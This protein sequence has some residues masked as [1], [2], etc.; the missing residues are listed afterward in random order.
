M[1]S[2]AH[3][4]PLAA[5]RL[6][7][8]PTGTGME[9]RAARR[10][11]VDDPASAATEPPL[12]LT[13][14]P[15]DVIDV[16]VTQAARDARDAEDPVGAICAWM[17]SFCKA[18][19]VQG[20]TGCDD[21]W[22]RLAL[23]AFG[24][25]PD[26]KKPAQMWYSWR[27]LFATACEFLHGPNAL[28]FVKTVGL[29]PAFRW[30]ASQRELDWE[31]VRIFES[32]IR[33]RMRDNPGT[34]FD[35]ERDV[36]KA[37]WEALSDP[38]DPR[39]QQAPSRIDALAMLLVLKGAE[40]WADKKYRALD[41]EIDTALN[42]KFEGEIDA[43]EALRLIRDAL[44]RGA[45]VSHS[46]WRYHIM[47]NQP[48]K[49]DHTLDSAVGANAGTATINLLL[50]RG[51]KALDDSF[52]PSFLASFL[53]ALAM[54]SA[55]PYW[56]ADRAATERLIEAARPIIR[57]IVLLHNPHEKLESARRT[58]DGFSRRHGPPSDWLT[59]AWKRLFDVTQWMDPRELEEHLPQMADYDPTAWPDHE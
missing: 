43:D 18:A 51:A 33:Y 28:P 5:L 3:L 29:P 20:V 46:G 56:S 50:D 30:N 42:R 37:S 10:R 47:T 1:R 14:L 22:Y 39:R 31:L 9:T 45:L 6:G 53:R 44:D 52:H 4:P 8:A 12:R 41:S 21:R 35:E 59:A 24:V 2:T 11:R 49:I 15:R 58:V 23:Q 48:I 40:P 25:P 19:K 34:E 54:E 26:A 36:Q 27:Y 7:T 16:M 13:G 32:N 57:D 55:E 38:N 17:Q